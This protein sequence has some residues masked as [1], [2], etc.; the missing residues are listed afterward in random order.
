[1]LHTDDPG[2]PDTPV[3]ARFTEGGVV[4]QYD[5][6]TGQYIQLSQTDAARMPPP[7]PVGGVPIPLP[8]P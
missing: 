6:I 7:P 2:Y 4:F 8:A 5:S 3:V 1:G